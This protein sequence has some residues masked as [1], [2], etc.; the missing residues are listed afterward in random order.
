LDDLKNDMSFAVQGF[1]AQSPGFSRPSCIPAAAYKAGTDILVIR[2]AATS[3]TPAAA[4]QANA[5]YLQ[6]RFDSYVLDLGQNDASFDLTNPMTNDALPLRR[7]RVDLYFISPCSDFSG[8]ACQDS[9]PTLKRL[10]LT[11]GP[12]FEMVT[13]VEGVEN[14]Q[15]FFGVDRQPVGALDGAP[16]KDANGKLYVANPGDLATPAGR[17]A[18]ANVVAVQL[19]LLTRDAAPTAGYT[20]QKTYALGPSELSAAELAAH[21]VAGGDSPYKR[22]VFSS[23]IRIT[24]ISSRREN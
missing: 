14:L 5:Y 1:D 13:L 3:A 22:Q 23:Q 8:G 11:A 19:Y 16:D 21:T 9:I 2:R 18:W 15:L 20:D 24:N 12:A 7:Y 10:E 4:V 17:E 6:S